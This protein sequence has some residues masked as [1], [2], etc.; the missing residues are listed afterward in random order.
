[1]AR[2]KSQVKFVGGKNT[3]STNKKMLKKEKPIDINVF[4]NA[5]NRKIVTRSKKNVIVQHD[6]KENLTEVKAS[7]KKMKLNKNRIDTSI[8]QIKPFRIVLTRMELNTENMNSIT[9][10]NANGI[11]QNAKRRSAKIQNNSIL[12]EGSVKYSLRKREIPKPSIETKKIKSSGQIVPRSNLFGA[13]AKNKWK[14]AQQQFKLSK[15]IL[16]EGL[17]VVAHMA[18]HRPWPGKITS[19][20]KNGVEI[21][22]F[23]S[24]NSGLVKKAEII[25]FKYCSEVLLEYLKTQINGNAKDT[26]YQLMFNKACSEIGLKW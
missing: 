5:T 6:G 19:F 15:E 16:H 8:H 26:M 2:V 23:G 7:L 22:F 4:S 10:S 25:P 14:K 13:Q 11:T 12:V 9:R 21:R 24:N 1:M 17:I 3:V 18:G 20:H